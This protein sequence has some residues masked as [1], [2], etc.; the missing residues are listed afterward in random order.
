MR[1][2]GQVN[3]MSVKLPTGKRLE[4]LQ[5]ADFARARDTIDRDHGRAPFMF[6]VAEAE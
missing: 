4:G 2:N 1:N 3:P 5:L 6:A